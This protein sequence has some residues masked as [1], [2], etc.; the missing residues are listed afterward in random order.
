[1][2]GACDS[3]ETPGPLLWECNHATPHATCYSCAS[4][5]LSGLK[6]LCDQLKAERDDARLMLRVIDGFYWEQE[7]CD[8]N[9]WRWRFRGPYT[10]KVQRWT[11]P[12]TGPTPEINEEVRAAMLASLATE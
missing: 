5:R 9:V 4:A 2:A 6:Q 7:A 10:T 3:M 11:V 1:M 12:R 8:E